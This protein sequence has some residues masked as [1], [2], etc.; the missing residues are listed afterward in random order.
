MATYKILTAGLAPLYWQLVSKSEPKRIYRHSCD[1][2]LPQVI[3]F[4]KSRHPG[5]F[6]TIDEAFLSYFLSDLKTHQVGSPVDLRSVRLEGN[7]GLV[8]EVI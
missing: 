3:R 5:I 1:I 8:L 2:I 6:E 7:E 4:N